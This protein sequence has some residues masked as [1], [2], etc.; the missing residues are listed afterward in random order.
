MSVHDEF[1]EMLRIL[2]GPPE[3]AGK[4]PPSCEIEQPPQGNSDGSENC[5]RRHKREGVGS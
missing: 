5:D 2:A 1:L 4:K 3:S